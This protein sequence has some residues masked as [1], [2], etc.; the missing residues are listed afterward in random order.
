MV[1]NDKK[2]KYNLR[3][4]D[5]SHSKK[6]KSSSK[7]CSEEDPPPTNNDYQEALQNKE[8]RARVQRLQVYDQKGEDMYNKVHQMLL[9]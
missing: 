9:R 6:E 2:K 5:K 1:Q 4:K 8:E 7:K 3:T